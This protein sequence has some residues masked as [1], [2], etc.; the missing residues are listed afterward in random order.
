MPFQILRRDVGYWQNGIYKMSD[1]A[2]T[3]QTIMATIQEPSSIDMSKIEATAF[4]RRASRYI[5]IYT[6]ER[7]RCVNQEIEGL[8]D[9]YAGDII[10]FDNS[11]YLL[12]G[13]TDYTML[14][15]SRNTA[16][17]HYRYYACETIEGFVSEVAP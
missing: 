12:F 1:V 10:Y 14:S 9:R 5:K 2:G 4:G 16:V 3:V 17:S 13:E 6:E 7:L 8:R 15:R 11:Q